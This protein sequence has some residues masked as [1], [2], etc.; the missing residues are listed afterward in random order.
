MYK[1]ASTQRGQ[2]A[3]SEN[4]MKLYNSF[5]NMSCVFVLIQNDANEI[6]F[7]FSGNKTDRNE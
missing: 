2:K 4:Q 3:E 6:E 7:D 1:L 5:V